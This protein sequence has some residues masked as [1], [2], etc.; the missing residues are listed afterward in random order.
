LEKPV[1]GGREGGEMHNAR[2]ILKQCFN[3]MKQEG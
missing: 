1:N 2:F 3:E